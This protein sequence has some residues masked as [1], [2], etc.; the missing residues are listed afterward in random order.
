MPSQMQD[1]HMKQKF[2]MALGGMKERFLEHM[3]ED[4]PQCRGTDEGI[5]VFGM[6]NAL[7]KEIIKYRGSGGDSAKYGQMDEEMARENLKLD[8]NIKHER[9]MKE[10]IINQTKLSNLIIKAEGEERVANSIKGLMSFLTHSISMYSAKQKDSQTV[11][12]E[13]TH[14]FNQCVDFLQEESEMVDWASDGDTEILRTRIL[15]VEAMGEYE[16]V[17]VQ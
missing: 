10:R 17:Q 3:Y 7:T 5:P 6:I 15:K 4:Y 14:C 12:K 13:L 11:M 2:F 8:T 9:L 16:E 1:F